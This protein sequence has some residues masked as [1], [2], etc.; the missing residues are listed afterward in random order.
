MTFLTYTQNNTLL[1]FV[2]TFTLGFGVYNII[3]NKYKIKKINEKLDCILENQLRF[4]KLLNSNVKDEVK[5]E[6]KDE[7]KEE[8]KDEVKDE[9]KDEVKEEIKDEVKDELKDEVKKEIKDD[10][11]DQEY[12]DDSYDNLP[13]ITK[14]NY[15]FK[16]W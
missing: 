1:T 14:S 12:L 4:I 16:F 3:I 13:V 2:T 10:N 5:E 7:V 8:I 9:L 15:I 6:I 11:L